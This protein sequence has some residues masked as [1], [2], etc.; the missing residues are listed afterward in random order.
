MGTPPEWQLCWPGSPGKD[1]NDT[2]ESLE[3]THR[4]Q[5]AS[6]RSKRLSLWGLFV[7]T[8]PSSLSQWKHPKKRSDHSK[9]YVRYLFGKLLFKIVS[10]TFCDLKDHFQWGRFLYS[11]DTGSMSPC[12]NT[13]WMEEMGPVSKQLPSLGSF[14]SSQ[15]IP[16]IVMG[17]RQ[18]LG[19]RC[20][21][22]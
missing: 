6:A 8:I 16:I 22:C 18:T 13:N 9:K 14:R 19:L 1:K 3:P 2:E 4:G 15:D 5:V 11:S 12:Q 10:T 21:S 7:P 17:L 20:S